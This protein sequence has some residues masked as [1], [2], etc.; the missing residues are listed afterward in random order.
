[1]TGLALPQAFL[2]I[3]ELNSETLSGLDNDLAEEVSSDL[4]WLDKDVQ[5]AVA[6]LKSNDASW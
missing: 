6:Q 3:K 5:D 1:V 4:Q 2:P